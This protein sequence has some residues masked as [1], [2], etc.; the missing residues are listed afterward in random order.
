MRK[1]FWVTAIA[2]LCAVTAHAAAGK[3]WIR[4]NQL[5]Y[6]PGYPKVAVFV[7]KENARIDSFEIR[8]VITD[9]VKY[10]SNGV[11]PYG[12]YAAFTNG[13]RLDFSAFSGKGAYYIDRKSVV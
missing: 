4:V 8:D 10:R 12:P 11:K 1:L 5:G 7:S 6:V 3:N 13:Y 9:E 2:F